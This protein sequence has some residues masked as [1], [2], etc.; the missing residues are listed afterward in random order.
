MGWRTGSTCVDVTYDMVGCVRGCSQSGSKDGR[1]SGGQ[2]GGKMYG[3]QWET[4]AWM[5]ETCDLLHQH[6]D[7]RSRKSLFSGPRETIP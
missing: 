7:P 6:L 4:R 1:G 3:R 2:G 5:R